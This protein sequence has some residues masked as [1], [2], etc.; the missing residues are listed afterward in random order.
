MSAPTVVIETLEG[1][2][3]WT[4]RYVVKVDG[5]EVHSS[6]SSAGARA[7]RDGFLAGAKG[8]PMQRVAGYGRRLVAA[9]A[10]GFDAGER[11]R[12][13]AALEQSREGEQA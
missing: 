4:E 13:N 12:I 7:W 11:W 9:Y 6:R 2:P 3:S 1:A 8:E 5:V 10:A